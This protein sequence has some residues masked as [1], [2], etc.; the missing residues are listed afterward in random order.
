MLTLRR[1]ANDE[2][3]RQPDFGELLPQESDRTVVL[4]DFPAFQTYFDKLVFSLRSPSSSLVIWGLV[5]LPQ[6]CDMNTR[7]LQLVPD[8]LNRLSGGTAMVE[9]TAIIS[10]TALL[11]RFGKSIAPSVLTPVLNRLAQVPAREYIDALALLVPNFTDVTVKSCIL[12][13]ID[14]FL[15][16]DEPYHMAAGEL[17]VSIPPE[18]SV[19]TLEQF[20]R[21]MAN[22]ILAN[23]YLPALVRI[24]VAAEAVSED[25]VLKTCPQVIMQLA[26]INPQIRT[27]AAR[28]MI[29]FTEILTARDQLGY[30]GMLFQWA[31]TSAPLALI[32]LGAADEIVQPTTAELIGRF[33]ALLGKLARSPAVECRAS[34]PKIIAANPAVFLEDASSLIPLRTVMEANL[35]E[36]QAAFLDSFVMIFARISGPGAS[37]VLF[38]LLTNCF[39]NPAPEIRTKLCSSDVYSLFGPAT[40]AQIMPHM[41]SRM[42]TITQPR[43]WIEFV[44]TFLSFPPDIVEQFWDKVAHV[45]FDAAA[46]FP[47]ALASSAF[48]FCSKLGLMVDAPDLAKLAHAI[49]A[50]FSAHDRYSV[51][52]LFPVLAGAVCVPKQGPVVVDQL[53]GIFAN[54]WKDPTVAVRA[55]VI[56]NLFR[57]RLYFARNGNVARERETM[58]LFL[59]F[60]RA[61]DPVLEAKYVEATKPFNVQVKKPRPAAPLPSVQI[62]AAG[63][64]PPIV[65]AQTSSSLG[66]GLLAHKFLP[67]AT[68]AQLR[69]Q[70]PANIRK[71]AGA[72][73]GTGTPPLVRKQTIRTDK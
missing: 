56:S 3:L 34:V 71:A 67:A 37:D 47:H 23:E 2:G 13:L 33:R 26:N 25:W 46:L 41:L 5:H 55:A 7:F 28:L 72:K 61:S 44:Q 64:E 57:I 10:L 51:R 22:T 53:F 43:E 20:P 42:E 68:V 4:P 14:R 17:L 48:R 19:I 32:L 11:Q 58:T 66:Q 65:L 18:F 38:K 30:F 62:G 24:A 15:A 49:L 54:M 69:A 6:A 52:A 29:S 50:K 16:K 40:L 21:F 1:L 27:G 63:E 9:Y 35:V 59:S 70:R 8:L 36:L 45:F 73:G 60:G 31:E 12:P 39:V